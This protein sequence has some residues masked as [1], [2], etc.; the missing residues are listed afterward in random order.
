MR[1]NV[2]LMALH[3]VR[4]ALT[5]LGRGIFAAPRHKSA[6]GTAQV[7]GGVFSTVSLNQPGES[8]GFFDILIIALG[9]WIVFRLINAR[10]KGGGGDSRWGNNAPGGLDDDSEDTP[11]YGR[12]ARYRAAEQAWDALRG[13]SARQVDTTGSP[14]GAADVAPD[15]DVPPGFDIEE[16]MKGA[17]IVYAR[18]QDA[19]GRR[20]IEDIRVFTTPAMFGEIQR[21]IREDPDPT[22]TNVLVVNARLMEIKAQGRV[23]T[24]V[25]YYEATMREDRALAS[26]EQVREV[27]TFTR[28]GEE[29][30]R[31]DGIEQ[32][33]E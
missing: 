4:T 30:W 26:T 33:E 21:Q 31:L 3:A 25:V 13:P 5:A 12:D 22:P 15:V 18:L 17:K 6:A 7:F 20:D 10:R 19:W 24:A 1:T 23:T 2:H 32:I 16:F 28:E 27:W 8:M 9:I 11:T 29:M 14:A